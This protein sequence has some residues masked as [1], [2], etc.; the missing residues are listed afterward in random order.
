MCEWGCVC[1][2]VGVCKGEC[3]MCAS[4]GV[5]ACKGDCLYVCECECLIAVPPVPVEVLLTFQAY[6]FIPHLLREKERPQINIA[7]DIVLPDGTPMLRAPPDVATV[8]HRF[9]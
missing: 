5:W 9:E 7:I 4:G 3:G 2:C 1:D 6:W 8:V